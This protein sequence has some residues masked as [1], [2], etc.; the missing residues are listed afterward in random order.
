MQFSTILSASSAVFAILIP[1]FARALELSDGAASAAF[2]LVLLTRGIA[3]GGHGIS[4]F[5]VKAVT[6]SSTE[7]N[8]LAQTKKSPSV[9]C[10]TDPAVQPSPG[11]PSV[12]LP[13]AARSLY[14]AHPPP[15]PVQAARA[16]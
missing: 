7:W 15:A 3:V 4:L 6:A 11:A 13:T 16:E 1:Q 14:L 10:L 12:S 5:P 9:L 8:S 2:G